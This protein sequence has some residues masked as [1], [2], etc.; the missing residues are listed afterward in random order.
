MDA[1][2]RLIDQGFWGLELPL[3]VRES[4][5]STAT[6]GAVPPQCYD[7][8]QPGTRPLGL[9]QPLLRGLDVRLVQL[10]LSDGGAD[11]KADGVFGQASV[12]CV[13]ELQ[14][15]RGLPVTGL[16][17]VVLIGDLVR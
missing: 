16:V 6:L 9:Q 4:E 5:I 17:D 3:V 13:K 1:F 7:G 15:A 14:I 8:P 12:R 11:I 2:Q 10:G